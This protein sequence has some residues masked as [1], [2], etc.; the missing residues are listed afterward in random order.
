MPLAWPGGPVTV[1]QVS[2]ADGAL[3]HWGA[4]KVTPW[5]E[6]RTELAAVSCPGAGELA[7]LGVPCQ[8]CE[9]L[10]SAPPPNSPRFSPGRVG[11]GA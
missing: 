8:G 5:L 3:A 9:W 1:Y 7:L 6:E 4:H 10:G 11:L 2:V